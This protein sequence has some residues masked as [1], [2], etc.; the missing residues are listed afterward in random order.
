MDNI[1]VENIQVQNIKIAHVEGQR[2]DSG[3][4]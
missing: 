1:P 4:L 3:E 2:Q